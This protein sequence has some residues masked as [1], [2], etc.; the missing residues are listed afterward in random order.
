MAPGQIEPDHVNSRVAR[1]PT[2][3]ATG[4]TGQLTGIGF[5]LQV[6]WFH[7]QQGVSAQIDPTGVKGLPQQNQLLSCGWLSRL[8][9]R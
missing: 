1:T 9:I 5:G 3:K 2:T 4:K 6:D 7:S 8:E